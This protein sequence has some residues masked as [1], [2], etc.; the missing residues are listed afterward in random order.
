MFENSVIVAVV[1]KGEKVVRSSCRLWGEKSVV[2][3]KEVKIPEEMTLWE[4]RLLVGVSSVIEGMISVG[5]SGTIVVSERVLPR[6]LQAK[7]MTGRHNGA[8]MMVL[9][10]MKTDGNDD[11]W[12]KCF[13]VL[14]RSLRRA[15]NKGINVRFIDSL[16]LFKVRI[17]GGADIPDGMIVD[18]R[19]GKSDIWGC[20]V[21]NDRFFGS[22]KVIKM[23]EEVWG[24]IIPESLVGGA[25]IFNSRGRIAVNSAVR[26]LNSA[27]GNSDDIKSKVVADAKA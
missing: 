6:L 22:I 12:K 10:W 7:K 26:A 23:K 27:V 19:Q 21:A 11:S 24:D 16:S 2:V 3:T 18:V 9:P 17:K 20:T 25:A 8:E 4:T 1:N 14:L 5:V 15:E 13:T